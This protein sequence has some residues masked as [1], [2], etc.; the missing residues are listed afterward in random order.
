MKVKKIVKSFYARVDAVLENLKLKIVDKIK[1]NNC[2]LI[3]RIIVISNLI[4]LFCAF[5]F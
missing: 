2:Q 1:W 5:S 4:S 3:A